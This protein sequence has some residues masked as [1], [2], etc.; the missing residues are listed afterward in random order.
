MCIQ[1]E[2]GLALSMNTYMEARPTTSMIKGWLC[3]TS[4]DEKNWEITPF[5]R[6]SR[7]SDDDDD[8]VMIHIWWW[9]SDDPALMM[10]Q[11]WW[12]R[13]DPVMKTYADELCQENTFLVKRDCW[14]ICN[15]I[16]YSLIYFIYCISLVPD[17]PIGRIINVIN[18][19]KVIEFDPPCWSGGKVP[20]VVG[21]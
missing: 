1:H 10:I 4:C 17:V 14:C 15:F 16:M 18:S 20:T 19:C 12:S 8:V 13:F 6:D 7:S 2:K 5:D 3:R 9:F 11:W 21:H